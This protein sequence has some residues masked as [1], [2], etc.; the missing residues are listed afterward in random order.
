MIQFESKQFR[1]GLIAYVNF[2]LILEIK[3]SY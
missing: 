1:P 2:K 3:P